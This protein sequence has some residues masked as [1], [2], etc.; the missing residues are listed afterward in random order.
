MPHYN[1]VCDALEIVLDVVKTPTTAED[2]AIS[3]R[4]ESATLQRFFITQNQRFF[5][6]TCEN[7]AL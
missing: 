4:G 6:S 5:N 7:K 1:P 2:K 3:A